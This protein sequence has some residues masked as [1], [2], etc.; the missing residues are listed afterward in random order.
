MSKFKPFTLEPGMVWEF[1][2]KDFA[3]YLD[4]RIG[5]YLLV[6]NGVRV[7]WKNTC[8]KDLNFNKWIDK[9]NANARNQHHALAVRIAALRDEQ[10]EIEIVLTRGPN[11]A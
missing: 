6:K 5:R 1:T 9:W 3:V 2:N 8:T 11:H 4:T 7:A 10:N